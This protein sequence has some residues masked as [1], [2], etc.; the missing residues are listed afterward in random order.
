[1]INVASTTALSAILALSTSSL[2]VSYLIPI[3]MM[4]IRRLDTSRGPIQFGPWSLG[5]FGMPINIFALLFGIFVCVFVPFPTQIPV[6]A[7][8]MNWSGPVFL[9]VFLLLVVD[10]VFRARKKF[11]GPARDLLQSQSKARS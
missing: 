9:G 3:V 5:R 8:N 2:Y 1:M 10:W 11:V 6:T 4:I 7:A